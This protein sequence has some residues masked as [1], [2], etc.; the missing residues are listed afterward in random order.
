[1]ILWYMILKHKNVK[2]VTLNLE[3]LVI[4]NDYNKK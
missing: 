4:N 1:M 2:K 3:N